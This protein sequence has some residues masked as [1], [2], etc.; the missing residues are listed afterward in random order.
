MKINLNIFWFRFFVLTNE[1]DIIINFINLK[2]VEI[3]FSSEATILSF[4]V[5]VYSLSSK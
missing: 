5:I 3:Y 4:F 2:Y 1:F